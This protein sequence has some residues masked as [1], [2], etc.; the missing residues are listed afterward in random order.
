MAVVVTYDIWLFVVRLLD[1]GFCV[2]PSSIVSVCM[3]EVRKLYL[4]KTACAGTYRSAGTV[5]V[6]TT[7]TVDGL[8]LLLKESLAK[9]FLWED[10]IADSLFPSVVVMFRLPL[11]LYLRFSLRNS[12]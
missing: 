10:L 3:W 5:G 8:L 9:L 1:S 12:S 4:M 2:P 6:G 11:L 7:S